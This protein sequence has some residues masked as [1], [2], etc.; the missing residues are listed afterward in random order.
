[1]CPI[2]HPLKTLCLSYSLAPFF[3]FFFLS[4]HS[5]NVWIRPDKKKW[6]MCWAKCNL[7]GWKQE[8]TQ[9]A[10]SKTSM[11]RTA[12]KE[13]TPKKKYKY[14]CVYMH[15]CMHNM[16]CSVFLY[17]Y[18]YASAASNKTV[19]NMEQKRRESYCNLFFV[20]LTLSVY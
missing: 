3:H 11:R 6:K 5:Y 7:R 12:K 2:Y 13:G 10:K 19:V 14:I 20:C 17:V 8:E 4:I 18:T 1:M 15:V 9:G 16:I